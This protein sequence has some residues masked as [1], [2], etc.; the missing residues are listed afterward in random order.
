MDI[1]HWS[2][3]IVT[4]NRFE[5]QII[6][7]LLRAAGVARARLFTD[8]SDALTHVT[9]E[10]ANV[11]IA[12]LDAAPTD[13]LAWVRALRREPDCR[14]REAPVFLH[15]RRLTASLAEECRHAGANAVTGMPMSNGTLLTTI[16]KV[17]A[18][19]RPFIEGAGYVGP[20]RRA[21]IVTAG[22]GSRRRRTD[23]SAA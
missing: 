8:S 1:A 19:P 18:R 2:V 4:P 12:A 20:C 23:A 3:A 17:L 15:A 5:G 14:S 16:K 21:G 7:D 10:K 6:V 11:L 9:H 22:A 13:G